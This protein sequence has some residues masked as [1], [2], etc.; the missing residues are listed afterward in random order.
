MELRESIESINEKLVENYNRDIGDGRPNYR[1]VWSD[2]QFEKRI[3]THDSHGNQL[4]HPEV[5]LLPKYKQYIR[6]RYIL[7]RLTLITGE[8]DLLEKIAYEVIWTFQDK[9]GK[10]LP[11]WFEACR[12]IIEN[13]L[14]NMAAKN[15]YTKY[16][17]TMS[18]EQYI[19]EIQKME[20]ELFGNESIITD[21]LHYG[22]GVTVPGRIQ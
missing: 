2:D 12:H 18:K 13:I 1:V 16:K 11:P 14:M 10:Y 8:T 15:Y 19:A 6:H 3:T 7:E 20:D 4:I 17:D 5:R 9:N 21:A 22:F